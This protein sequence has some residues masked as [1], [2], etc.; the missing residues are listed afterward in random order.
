MGALIA[1]FFTA[2][3]PAA[4][5]NV[6]TVSQLMSAVNNGA[7]GDTINVAAGTYS[8]TASLTPKNSMIIQG[9][10]PTT[11]LTPAG[12]WNPN[13]SSLPD[14]GVTVSTV[15]RDA[16]MFSFTDFS[17][18][19]VIKNMKLSGGNKLHGAVFGYDCANTEIASS[20][21]DG[22][23][24]SSIRTF[25]QTGSIHDNTFIDA[26]GSWS[27]GVSGS[28]IAGGAMYLTWGRS[29]Q[30][31]NNR[32]SG[33]SW[34]RGTFFGIKC[35][36]LR[37]SRIN[38]NTINVLFSGELPFEN[39]YTV[40]IDHNYTGTFSFPKDSGGSVP[41]GTYSFLI[42]HN[43]FYDGYAF[44]FPR[45]YIDIHHNLF[46]FT[47][48]ND[49]SN[50]IS[51]WNN[52]TAPGPCN[53][54]ENR[55]KNPGRGVFWKTGV[56]NN[57]NF[58]NNHVIANTTVTPRTEGLFDFNTLTSFPTI[59]LTNNIIE[60][61]GTP[62]P[63]FR[64]TQSYAAVIQ[65]N[66]LSN[67]SDS[68][69][70]ANPNTGAT[71]GLTAPLSFT[72]GVIG[73]KTVS[74]WTISNTTGGTPPPTPTGLSATPGNTQVSL[75]W[76][77]SSGASSYNV[78]RFTTSGGPYTTVASGVSS[79]SYLNT[80]LNN[81]TTYYYVV[82][83]V[84]SFGESPNS[85]EVS[86][87]P[88]AIVPPNPP[89]SLN[90][91]TPPQKRI[92]DLTWT[93]SNSPGISQN[94]IYRSTTGSSGPYSLIATLSPT[95]SYSNTGLTSRAAYFYVVTAVSPNGESIF[96]SYSGATAK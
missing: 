57:F 60:C 82:S 53:F 31:Y 58:Y 81:G 73:E 21:I 90:A 89:T 43:Y 51:S 85:S 8:M 26:G 55:I 20:Q 66:T 56:F 14:G 83:A 49:G 94:K 78:K 33:S 23:I 76:A 2:S 69:S 6:S 32:I 52:E 25:I 93:Q 22:F 91:T 37:N 28:G 27:G 86:A 47:T 67:V 84:N 18:G 36:E 11:I 40:E 19:I 12:S 96:S 4:T 5:V 70:Y 1:L 39:D 34:P 64:N 48:T 71:R 59:K 50:L 9:A 41:A 54:Y 29:L 75:G 46:D 45:N 3:L 35:R 65:N 7:A 42:H 17:S 92:I 80:G 13:N 30:I 72:C 77:A 38:N 79:T 95:T 44:E 74:D 61:N 68:A 88:Q 24:W 16:Y 63:L 15:Q 62:R 10:G 87:T